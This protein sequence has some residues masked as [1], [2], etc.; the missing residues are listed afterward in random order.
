MRRS[1]CPRTW[2][3]A[4]LRNPRHSDP[5]T[6]TREPGR[7][8][9]GA[10]DEDG[11]LLGAAE[12][13]PN[14]A[15]PGSHMANAR[16]MVRP[17]RSGRGIGRVL[18]EHVIEQARADGYPGDP[19]QGGRRDQHQG[20]GAGAGWPPEGSGPGG[21]GRILALPGG[22]AAGGAEGGRAILDA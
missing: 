3:R 9:R 22:P 21:T 11:T 7:R 1:G 10:V 5:G 6:V 12:T 14:Q 13:H 16:F 19:V 4:A 17:G 15:G 20:G 8:P 18:G 2:S